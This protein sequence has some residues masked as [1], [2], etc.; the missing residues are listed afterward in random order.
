MM[1]IY[2]LTSGFSNGFPI[3]FVSSLRP[4]IKNKAKFAFVASEF[5]KNHE[6]TDRFFLF[7]LNMFEKSSIFFEESCVIDARMTPE[8]MR[9]E[10]EAADV[11]WLA[12]GVSPVQYQ[13]FQKYGLVPVLKQHEGVIIGMSA[14]SI[15]MAQTAICVHDKIEINQALGLV[16]ISVKPHFDINGALDEL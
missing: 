11:V 10:I 12:G 4:I 13:Y 1:S 14:G 9:K 7:F 8:K 2:I 5:E 16:D 3:D 15:N 6:K